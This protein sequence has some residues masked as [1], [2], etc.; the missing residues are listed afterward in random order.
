MCFAV[1]EAAIVSTVRI[2]RREKCIVDMYGGIW[3]MVYMGGEI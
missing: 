1:A 2:E 3:L